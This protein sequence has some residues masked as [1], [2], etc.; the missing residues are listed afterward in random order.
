MRSYLL[1]HANQNNENSI[2]SKLRKKRFKFFE[3][4]CG[5]FKKPLH[6]LDL[7]GSDYHWRSS[8]FE[9]NKDYHIT[10]LNV[11]NQNLSGLKNFSY[12]R[13]DVSELD[14]FGDREFE[15]IY[16]NSLIEHL[17]SFEEQKK[18][19]KEI[20]R[21]GKRYFVQTPN[22]NFPVEPHFLFPFFQFLPEETKVKL[23]MK[24]NLGWYEKQKVKSAAQELARSINMLNKKKLPEIFPDSKIRS[25]HFFLL[26]KSFIVYN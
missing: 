22:L 7:G 9:N 16:S 26:T 2:S 25:E 23:L 21:I 20:M 15:L 6:I 18:L 10:L 3:E 12:I 19:G 4:Y 24:H 1:K 13:L 8:I 11:E 14:Y 5:Q 17:P